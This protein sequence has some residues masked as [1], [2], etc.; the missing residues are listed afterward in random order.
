MPE[1]R[2]SSS[3]QKSSTKKQSH[4]KSTKLS[5]FSIWSATEPALKFPALTKNA[6]AD[7]CIVGAGIAGLTTGYLLAQGP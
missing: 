7:I 3:K 1:K 6:K 4:K 2:S 5:N